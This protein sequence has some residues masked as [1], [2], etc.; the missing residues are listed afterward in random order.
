LASVPRTPLLAPVPLVSV[1]V[2]GRVDK[3]IDA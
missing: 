1:P 3:I 2:L